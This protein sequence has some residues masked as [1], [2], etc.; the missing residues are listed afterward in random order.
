M[1]RK[2]ARMFGK[3]HKDDTLHPC[4]TGLVP[5]PEPWR[6][7]V[8]QRSCRS[9]WQELKIGGTVVVILTKWKAKPPQP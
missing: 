6:R 4:V 9:S 2:G 7:K 3:D 8:T 5:T 1:A